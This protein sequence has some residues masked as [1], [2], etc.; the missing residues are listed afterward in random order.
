MINYALSQVEDKEIQGVLEYVL[1]LSEKHV[2]FLTDLCKKGK[3]AVPD[4]FSTEDVNLH[5][6]RLFTDD[7]F[8]MYIQNLGKIGLTAYS[9]ALSNAA[10]SDIVQYFKQCLTSSAELLEK[11]IEVKL[12]K[13]IFARAPFIPKQEKVQYVEKQHYMGGGWFSE[14]RP[15]NA[16]EIT[17]LYYNI[18]RNHLGIVLIIGF[19]QVAHSKEVQQYMYRGRDISRKYVE[20]FSELL[21]DDYLAVSSAWDVQATGSTK[22]PFSDKLMMFHINTMNASGIGQYGA[23]IGMSQ[24]ADLVVMYTR[25]V[26]EIGKFAVDGA[27]IMINNGWMEKPPQA[28]DRKQIAKGKG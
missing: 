1:G 20:V 11:S 7:F 4:G 5:A 13:G 18:E 19:S 24:R 16:I 6:P 8:I 15:L 12:S 14:K 23:S 10:R 9:K 21:R 26:A 27:N 2:T 3:L 25:L 17:H 22:S 28:I